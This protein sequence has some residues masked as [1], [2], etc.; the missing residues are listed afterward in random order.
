MEGT[1]V[2]GH[3]GIDH[4]SDHFV[5]NAGYLQ[6]TFYLAELRLACR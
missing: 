4:T 6:D 2:F 5:D 1:V 3:T